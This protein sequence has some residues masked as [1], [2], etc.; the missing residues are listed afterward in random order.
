MTEIAPNNG[1][2]YQI[3]VTGMTSS[4]T[5]IASIV[6][7]AAVNAQGNANGTPSFTDRSVTYDVTSPTVT[8]NQSTSGPTQ[9]DPSNSPTL[10]FYVRFNEPV[11][12]TGAGLSFAGSTASG[13]LTVGSIQGSG[14][15]YLVGITGMTS[16]GTVVVSVPAGQVG[17]LA[18]NLNAASTSTDNQVT[19]DGTVPTVTINQAATQ[20]DPAV[21]EPVVFTVT[22]SEDVSGF[23]ASDVLLSGTAGGSRTI[24]VVPVSAQV[25]RVEITNITSGTLIADVRPNSAQDVA[26]NWASGSTST[27]NSVTYP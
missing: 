13:T 14:A 3:S 5:V 12:F 10:Y 17:D 7:G 8:V 21:S 20:V 23:D 6:S 18:G 4:G 11:N 25:Y 15:V 24:T 2:T 26:L 19:Y 9:S 22:Y 27:D 1:T 16:S